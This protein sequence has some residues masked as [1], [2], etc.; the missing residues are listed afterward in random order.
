MENNTHENTTNAEGIDIDPN[1]SAAQIRD[2]MDK[3][4]SSDHFA[5]VSEM[6]IKDCMRTGYHQN[7]NRM[8][9]VWLF[10]KDP[11]CINEYA[12]QKH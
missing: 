1:V 9:L 11:I 8:F 3:Q 7:Q 2:M 5:R 12:L 10:N 4:D 6:Y